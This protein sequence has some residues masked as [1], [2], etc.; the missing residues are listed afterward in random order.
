MVFIR[1][2]QFLSRSD[3]EAEVVKAALTQRPYQ[4]EGC[5]LKWEIL[6]VDISEKPP[7]IDVNKLIVRTCVS[8]VLQI[9][10]CVSDVLQ[11]GNS[12]TISIS[13]HLL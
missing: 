9:G 5:F 3:D 10:T 13:G 7:V 2:E 12:S 8:D 1:I 11:I 6:K 4:V